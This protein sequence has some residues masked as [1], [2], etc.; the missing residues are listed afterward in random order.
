MQKMPALIALI[1]LSIA[2]IIFVNKNNSVIVNSSIPSL[3]GSGS[4]LPNLVNVTVIE[5][6]CTNCYDAVGLVKS[7]EAYG[8]NIDNFNV[9]NSTKALISDYSLARLPAIVFS[10]NITNYSFYTA[11]SYYGVTENNSFVFNLPS[12]PF[13]DTLKNEIV[14]GLVNV[15]II[16]DTQ[17]SDC[18]NA[19][20]H[21]PI[22]EAY[23]VNVSEVSYANQ[24]SGL[25]SKYNITSLPTIVVSSEASLYPPLMRVW[26][27]V[28]SIESD[29]NLVFTDM[30]ALGNVTY[31]NLTLNRT[32]TQ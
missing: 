10:S 32:V 6:N 27:S 22:L 14:Y 5:P 11:L 19:T 8:L 30:T 12:P 17:C 24:S 3:S 16:N 4:P 28:G 31:F 13:F 20:D 26:P 2:L 18:Y 29:G 25:V 21:I 23:G 15:T 7:L 1:L 9:V